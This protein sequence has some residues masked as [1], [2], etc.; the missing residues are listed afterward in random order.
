MTK[1]ICATLEGGASQ[2]SAVEQAGLAPPPYRPPLRGG[3]KGGAVRSK[4]GAPERGTWVAH[5]LAELAS[6][7]E[8]LSVSH[9]DP[10][11]FFVER[12]EIA[13]ELRAATRVPPLAQPAGQGRR[14]PSLACLDLA[15]KVPG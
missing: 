2:G 3:R 15:S 9:R 13:S 12:S 8:R 14:G 7:V 11:A 1:T 4:G 10:E 6:R 5:D